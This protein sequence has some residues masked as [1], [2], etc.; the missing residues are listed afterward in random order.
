MAS[1]T[2]GVLATF[3]V[4][5]SQEADQQAA[6]SGF[7]VPGVQSSPGFV[8][9]TW[10]VDREAGQSFAL[11]TFSSEATARDFATNVRGNVENQRAVGI[12]LLSVR[13]VEIS[14]TA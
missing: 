7:I 4:D 8:A 10:T 2:H 6:L 3:E 13:L 1:S 5:L 12:T 9:G 14:A 11:V